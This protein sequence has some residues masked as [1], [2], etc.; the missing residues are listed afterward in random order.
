VARAEE[1]AE[2]EDTTLTQSVAPS[3]RAAKELLEAHGFELVRHFWK[4]GIDLDAETPAPAWPDG[5]RLETV[6]GGRE[7]EVY[8]AAEEAFRDHWDHAPHEWEEWRAMMVERRGFDPSLWLLARDGHEIAGLSLCAL[9]GDEGWVNVLG[10]RRSWRRRGIARAL[11]LESFSRLRE[12]GMRRAVLGVDA[13]N[14]TGA[15]QLY[16]QAGMRVLLQDDAYR[17]QLT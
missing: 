3:N 16:E 2:S 13:S 9:E 14:P 4:M 6:E 7:R 8:E 5:I 12:R 1:L 15:T 17:K 10:V 11:L